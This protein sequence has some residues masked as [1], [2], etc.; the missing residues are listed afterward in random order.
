MDLIFRFTF[1]I[2]DK[3][4]YMTGLYKMFIRKNS[5]Q[6][7]LICVLHISSPRQ[8]LLVRS[9]LDLDTCTTTIHELYMYISSWSIGRVYLFLVVLVY[10]KT[11]DFNKLN[12]VFNPM[13]FDNRTLHFPEK[14]SKLY[15]KENRPLSSTYNV[16][17]SSSMYS[18]L[19]WLY[20]GLIW[21]YFV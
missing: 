4:E 5:L 15:T 3:N 20:I 12:I 8:M 14:T 13:I 6:K 1:F 17:R 18:D 2:N 7:L 19:V 9:V 10:S 16:G 11:S 21:I